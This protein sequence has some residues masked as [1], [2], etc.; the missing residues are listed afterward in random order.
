MEEV[1]TVKAMDAVSLVDFIE[2]YGAVL[3]YKNI[4]IMTPNAYG[5]DAT[6]QDEMI[7][8]LIRDL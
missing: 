8:R 4:S 3:K 6:Y 2:T 1:V 5:V 7:T